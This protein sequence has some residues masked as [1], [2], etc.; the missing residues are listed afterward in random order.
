MST[1]LTNKYPNNKCLSMMNN[2]DREPIIIIINGI[3][4]SNSNI[5]TD[6]SIIVQIIDMI[7]YVC[8]ISLLYNITPCGICQ[9]LQVMQP[10]RRYGDL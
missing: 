2:L 3:I 9:P 10:S 4:I 8:T 5:I 1:V 7:V 6:I